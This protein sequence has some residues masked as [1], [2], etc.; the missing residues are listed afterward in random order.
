MIGRL[1]C[2]FV[3]GW[4]GCGENVMSVTKWQLRN[5]QIKFSCGSFLC[6]KCSTG[7]SEENFMSIICIFESNRSRVS[8]N[9]L[10]RMKTFVGHSSSM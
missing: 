9:C 3:G 6:E 1:P 4:V 2:I 10:P 5:K 8:K 7:Q